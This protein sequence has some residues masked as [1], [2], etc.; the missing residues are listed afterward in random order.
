[1]VDVTVDTTLTYLYAA[2]TGAYVATIA[3]GPGGGVLCANGPSSFTPPASCSF[4]PLAA[5]A[6]VEQDGGIGPTDG[7]PDAADAGTPQGMPSSQPL[8][9]PPAPQAPPG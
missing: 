5:C 8:T 7:S 6:P 3:E 2:G 1:V 4:D 9:E